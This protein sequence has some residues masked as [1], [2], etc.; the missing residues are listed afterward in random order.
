VTRTEGAG[1]RPRASA[2]DRRQRLGRDGE[3]AAAAVLG[4]AGL[5][6]LE[7][8]FR[9]RAGEL[10][11]IAEQGDLL[12][13][14]EVKARR[15]V[16]CGDPAEAVTHAKRRRMARVALAYLA[17]TDALDRPCRFDVVEVHLGPADR[18]EAVRH[19][20]DAFRIWPTG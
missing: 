7:R 16:G 18:V 11:L 13:F 14:V 1:R 6:I 8:R 17:A 5:R 19:L 2:S 10:D 9:V 12:V 3:A 4:R 20:E 15:Q